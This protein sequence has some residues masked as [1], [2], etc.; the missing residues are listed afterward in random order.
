MKCARGFVMAIAM[1]A[2]AGT[3]YAADQTTSAAPKKAPAKLDL[4]TLPAAVRATVEAE[5]KNATLKGLSKEVEKG[6]T[7]YEVETMVNGRTRDLLVDPAGTVLEV[8]EQLD[9][10]SAPAP[11]KAA[12]E[13]KG[14][15][16]RLE[17]LTKGS[18]VTYEALVQAK[19][20]K[21]SEISLDA[22]GKAIK[23]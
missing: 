21:K 13:T 14:K 23:P 7:Q 9:L 4:K 15:L 20:G 6:K 19:S 2:I 1:V 3:A 16:L 18:V 8:E 5:T 22:S 12:L 10:Q 17:T 11:V